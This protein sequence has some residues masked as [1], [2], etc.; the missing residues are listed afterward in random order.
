MDGFVFSGVP[1]EFLLAAFGA[2]LL[3]IGK[4]GVKGIAVFIVTLFVFAFGARPSTGILMPL[5]IMGDIFAIIYYKRYTEWKYVFVLIPWMVVGVLLGTYFGN[6]LDENDFKNAMAFLIFLTS[7]ILF[8]RERKPSLSVPKHWSF[9]GILGVLAGFTTMIGNLA[10]AVTNIYFLAMKLPKNV[11]IGTS[12]NVFFMINVF[13]VPFHVYVWKTI[14]LHS[15]YTSLKFSP[16]LFLG[17]LVGVKMVERINDQNYR[18]FILSL[19]AVG[20]VILIL[21]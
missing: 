2:F 20:S 3:G 16:F 4:A 19:T 17:L 9:G 18:W 7:C 21:K 10:G 5:L 1:L 14:D 8:Y 13:K 11:F 15:F 6:A 12:A